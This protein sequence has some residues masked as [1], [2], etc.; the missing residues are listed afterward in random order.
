MIPEV[1][2]TAFSE[3]AAHLGRLARVFEQKAILFPFEPTRGYPSY[4][5]EGG[6]GRFGTIS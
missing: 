5:I 1:L 6:S 2:I 4:K 3:R